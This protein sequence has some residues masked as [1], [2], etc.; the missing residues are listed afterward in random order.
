MSERF[1]VI[2]LFFHSV[3]GLINLAALILLII[4]AF[5]DQ[6]SPFRHI[7]FAYLGL[8]FPILFIINCCF[9]LY[10]PCLRKWIIVICIVLAFFVCRDAITASFPM[11]ISR[12]EIPVENKIKVLTY[13]V[14]G[15]G[16]KTHTKENPNDIISYIARS[17]ADIVC[18]QEYAVGKSDKTIT[19]AQLKKALSM[20]PYRAVIPTGSSGSL[21]F[22]IAVLSKYPIRKSRKIKYDSKFNGSSIHEIDINGKK[23]TLINNHLESFKLTTE[24]K[25]HYTSFLKHLNSETFDELKSS[26]HHKLGPAYRIRARQAEII[27]EEI[28]NVKTDYLLVCGDFNDTPVSYAHRTIQGPLTDAFGVAGF[29]P[30]ITYN[31]NMFW[32][33][34]DNIFCSPNMHPHQCK[35][36][37]VRYSDHYPVWSVIE[38]T[39]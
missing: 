27:A 28:K 38:L 15:F 30:G 2:R 31:E 21:K 13:N 35:V 6:F 12:K 22:G 1:K 34:I 39:D 3:V 8:A 16:Y 9:L 25:S 14:M 29:G 19:E 33:R 18:L 4:S 26:I 32:F 17:D 10:W 7:I 23:L 5:S 24:D 37:K 20:Y 11:R 36:D